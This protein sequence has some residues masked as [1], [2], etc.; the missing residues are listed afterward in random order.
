M[1]SEITIPSPVSAIRI[2]VGRAEYSVEEL[3][4][5]GDW[6]VF[7]RGDV[8]RLQAR[9]SAGLPLHE[10]E[11]GPLCLVAVETE[12][13]A[14]FT[15]YRAAFDRNLSPEEGVMVDRAFEAARRRIGARIAQSIT[16]TVV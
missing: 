4:V 2:T 15:A 6:P 5:P 12:D 7:A 13:M 14:A 10:R 3:P 1:S 16:A 8:R 9:A 11:R